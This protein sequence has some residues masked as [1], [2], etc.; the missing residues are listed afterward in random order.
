MSTTSAT[1]NLKAGTFVMVGL[2]LT[3]AVLFVLTD[4]WASMFGG[5]HTD[6]VV[7]YPVEDG[8][9]HLAPGSEVRIGGILSGDVTGITLSHESGAARDVDVHFSLSSD[10]TL[11]SNAVIVVR[12]GLIGSSSSLDVISVGWDAQSR[13]G[14]ATGDPGTTVAAGGTIVGTTAGGM[15]GSIVGPGASQST[16]E[17]LAN[18]AAITGRLRGDGHLLPWVVGQESAQSVQAGLTDMGQVMQRLKRD[19][20]LLQWAMGDAASSDVQETLA[21]AR[22]T[23]TKLQAN[24]PLW[25]SAVGS[26]LANLDLSSQ[27]MNLMVQELRNSPWRLLYRPTADEASNELIYA[28]SR[29]FVFGA[30]DLRSAADSLDRLIAEHGDA[31]SAQP[32]W[33]VLQ[34]HLE[35]AAERYRRAEDQLNQVLQHTGAAQTDGT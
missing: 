29:N 32:A 7:T 3:I 14:N 27:Q 19:G 18:L 26:T 21:S 16:S 12:S 17:M 22:G 5:R 34:Q 10:I 35:E 2:L 25:S 11:Y 15:L 30:A 1:Q 13:M 33:G 8:V 31:A 28:A 24:W 4:A 9:D 20:E 6:Y 23:M